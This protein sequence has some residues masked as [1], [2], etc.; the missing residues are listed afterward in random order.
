MYRSRLTEVA[1]ILERLKSLEIY[2]NLLVD[3]NEQIPQHLRGKKSHL[4]QLLP[5]L[6]DCVTSKEAELKE[7]L[8]D[9]FFEISKELGIPEI[10]T[11]GIK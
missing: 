4:I 3:E 6:A 1:F 11:S 9:I 7:Y 5:L 10:G 2:P 8:K